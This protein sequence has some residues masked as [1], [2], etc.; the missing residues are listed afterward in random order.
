MQRRLGNDEKKILLR[1][2]ASSEEKSHTTRAR[3]GFFFTVQEMERCRS[4]QGVVTGR[5]QSEHAAGVAGGWTCSCD[6]AT[7]LSRGRQETA[8]SVVAE[9]GGGEMMTQF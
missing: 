6:R 8:P 9:T 7:W 2:H 1:A 3:I 5:R 4:V